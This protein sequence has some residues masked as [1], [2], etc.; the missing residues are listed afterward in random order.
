MRLQ[1]TFDYIKD[2]KKLPHLLTY[3]LGIFAIGLFYSFNVALQL[4]LV[5]LTVAIYTA[6]IAE[7]FLIIR[8]LSEKTT[9][10][11][12]DLIIISFA[13]IIVS[14][15]NVF[16]LRPKLW[17]DIIALTITL[18]IIIQLMLYIRNRKN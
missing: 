2:P 10:N 6:L 17:N 12:K 4:V 11:K 1:Q 14:I 7:L 9:S 3:V 8:E 13:T 16:A 18:T 5:F 15:I